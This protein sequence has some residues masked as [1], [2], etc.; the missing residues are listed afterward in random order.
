MKRIA[1]WVIVVSCLVAGSVRPALANKI[2]VDNDEW[3]WTNVGLASAPNRS[4]FALNVANFFTGG[5]AGSFLIYSDNFGLNESTFQS[6]MTGAGHTLTHYV[7]T[8][9]LATLQPLGRIGWGSKSRRRWYPLSRSAEDRPG[10][11][12]GV[13][14]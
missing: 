3:T 1:L 2:V 13:R 4:V 9:T 8:P 12:I 11:A 10:H 6:T 14:F 7:G 5:G